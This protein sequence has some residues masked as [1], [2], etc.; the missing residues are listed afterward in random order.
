M[1]IT[2]EESATGGSICAQ[3][4]K[5]ALE[6]I[7]IDGGTQP[8][9]AIYQN[10][11]DDYTAAL[12]AGAKFPPVVIFYDGDEYWLADGFHRY[13]AYA[14]AG[15]EDIPSDIREGTCRDAIL[16][17]VGANESHGLRRT[18]EDKR[19]AVMILLQDEEWGKWSNYEIAKRC[20]V[21]DEMVR[22]MRASLPSVGS[23]NPERTY[24]TKHGTIATMDTSGIGGTR[25]ARVDPQQAR[26]IL[27][28]AREIRS[29]QLLLD[30]AREIK[31]LRE[32]ELVRGTFGTGENEWYTPI[33][34][35]EAA[36]DVLGDI[37]I[38]PATSELAQQSIKAK[39]FFTADDSG[40]DK[41]WEGR[42]WLNPPYAQPLIA[43]FVS[44]MVAERKAKNVSAA[45]MLTHNYT[46]TSWFHEAAAVADAI[47][48]TRGRVKFVDSVGEIAAPTQGQA[49]FYF[50]DNVDSF[51]KRFADIGFVVMP[52]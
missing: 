3:V 13:H 45:I 15:I 36:R 41:I 4:N 12:A 27:D 1:Q 30:A 19:R 9:S 52:I 51:V 10:V 16:H 14:K 28:V 11:I 32:H 29:D 21:S 49:F 37:D 33:E 17:S 31:P 22:Q 38:D 34:Q 46:D 48:F 18:N 8:R 2:V 47:C 43:E 24:L 50:G 40:L 39:R 26:E 25:I 35:I 23:D 20:S 44:K 5:L 7:R 42:V 6:K